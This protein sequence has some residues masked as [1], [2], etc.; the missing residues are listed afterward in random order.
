MKR[1]AH[2]RARGAARWLALAL[3]SS[4][5]LAENVDPIGADEQYAWSENAGWLN[6]QPLGPGGPGMQVDDFWVTGWIWAENLG[7]INLNCQ[8]NGTCDA[9]GY[10]VSNNGLGVLEGFAWSEN[11]GWINFR[12]LGWAS[13][14]VEIDPA[15][16]AFTGWA[17]GEN[18]GWVNFDMAA[19]GGA[20]IRTSWSCDPVPVPPHGSPDLLLA[21]IG[22][23]TQLTWTPVPGAS[24]FD[25]VRGRIGLLRDSGGDFSVAEVRCAWRRTRATSLVSAST[26]EN[27]PPGD[28]F[29]FLV[30]GANCGGPGTYDTAGPGQQGARDAEIQASGGDC[31]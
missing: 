27:P 11:A 18:I 13:I 20:G 17:W 1:H 16:G 31:R 14:G 22:E 7:W 19:L 6:A 2:F 12:P 24:A 23:K 8:N 26:S 21:R 28:G 10:G 15:T 30:R 25:V 29:W 9:A 5:A 3:L 4:V